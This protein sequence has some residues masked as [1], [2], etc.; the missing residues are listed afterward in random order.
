MK[1][2]IIKFIQENF[3]QGVSKQK[4]KETPNTPCSIN[5]VVRIFKSWNTALLN[6][7]VPINDISPLPIKKCLHCGKPTKR[8]YCSRSCANF[9]KPRRK[10]TKQCANCKTLIISS[11]KYCTSCFKKNQLIILRQTKKEATTHTGKRSGAYSKIREHARRICETRKQ[12]CIACGY[13]KHVEA[14]HLISIKNFSDDAL[15]S[16]INHPNNLVLLCRNCH[17]ELDHNMLRYLNYK[18]E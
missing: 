7:N 16:I 15:I 6:A 18:P 2:K 5:T 1:E 9:H 10:K 4:W 3:P 8:K 12:E 17:W 13:S 14:C 11:K